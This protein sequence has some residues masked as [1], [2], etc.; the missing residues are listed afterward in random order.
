MEKK[1]LFRIV[2]II[3]LLIVKSPIVK[4]QNIYYYNSDGTINYYEKNNNVY[5]FVIHDFQRNDS[6]LQAIKN[7]TLNYCKNSWI[8]NSYIIHFSLRE[9]DNISTIKSFFNGVR[10][11][12]SNILYE[13]NESPCW[14]YNKLFVKVKEN[15]S[16]ATLLQENHIPVYNYHQ[17]GYDENT[18]VVD[19]NT[20]IDSSIICSNILFETGSVIF[21]QPDMWAVFKTA[22]VLQ[23]FQWNTDNQGQYNNTFYDIDINAPEAWNLSSGSGIKVAVID[24]GIDLNHP[25]LSSNL[26]QGVNVTDD[27]V[28]C[29][30]LGACKGNDAHG[31]ACA[32]IIA[33]ED[34]NFGVKGIAYNAE[35]IPI[36]LSYKIYDS[37]M[38]VWV[39][40]SPRIWVANAIHKAWSVYGADV[41]SC[42]WENSHQDIITNEIRGAINF[43]RNGNGCVV[44]F[45]AGNRNYPQTSFYGT[46]DTLL[47]VGA[48]SPCGERKS[49]NSCD[50]ENLGSDYGTYLDIVAPGV[51][52]PTTDIHG[53]SG[54]NPDRMLHIEN[55]GNMLFQDCDSN[56]YTLMFSGTSAAAPHVAAVAALVLSINPSLT[57]LEVKEII[58]KSAQ[59]IR[60]DLYSYDPDPV[61][62]NGSW[63][64][65][66][67][68][69]LV[70]AYAAV[71]AAGG[72]DLYT[73]DNDYDNLS[74][75]NTGLLSNIFYSPDI[76]VRKYRDTVTRS[77]SITIE[78]TNYVFVRVHNN[79][80]V[81]SLAHNDSVKIYAKAN[82]ST[83]LGVW[84]NSWIPLGAAEIPEIPAGRDTI[85][86]VK[87]EFPHIGSAVDFAI[88]SRIES[89]A[90]PL[91]FS[92]TNN[93]D[94]NVRKNN[95]IS[96][97]NVKVIDHYVADNREANFTIS[98]ISN[99]ANGWE[100]IR[101]RF[102]NQSQDSTILDFADITLELSDDLM[103]Y[104]QDYMD[105]DGV[106]HIKDNEYLVTER[107]VTLP[108]IPNSTGEY[109]VT[110]KYNFLTNKVTMRDFFNT[111]VLQYKNDIDEQDV[112]IGGFT[113]QVEKPKRTVAN[114]FH[115]NAGNDTA[116]LLNTTA[117]LHATQINED[118]TYRWY[119]KQRNF[120]YEGLNYSIIPSQTSE[121]ILEVTAESDGYRD[122]DTVKVNVLPGCI[123]SITPNP[124]S[125]NWI[126][127]SYEYASTVTSAQLLIYNTGTTT[128]VGSYDL[129]NL[130]NVS[131]LD[132]EV[133]NYP[134]GS[135]TVVLVCDNAVCHSKVLIRQ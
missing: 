16:I 48:I 86:C 30:S 65:E 99:N 135:Y 14:T 58:E 54:Y 94:T 122:L 23:H 62:P 68:Y 31:T 107:S 106:K 56:N 96:A 7:N 29:G 67:G 3:V 75:P 121:Y 133:T 35:L 50:G 110:I 73:R 91:A 134:T 52:I 109:S 47:C 22:N 5:V 45:A 64:N 38:L 51:L 118:A 66:M 53:V 55:G 123:R 84:N 103:Y 108:H 113:I 33:A 127:V 104:W 129:S 85:V 25:D 83:N 42:S 15:V 13:E 82:V 4:S 40:Y 59:K 10:Y 46:I 120:K 69:G 26:L 11:S 79:G 112:L 101:I 132:V 128:L 78:G 44:V 49:P 37:T 9:T 32:G 6:L 111:Y 17:F 115:A 80:P 100:D 20:K 27:T 105:I 102:G 71:R 21:A 28:I 125:G 95:N 98:K 114:R 97:I 119:D 124:V 43:G 1:F 72:Y 60:T 18:F 63:N 24:D 92:E 81:S 117:T 88:Y 93:A 61:H 70:D 87:V 41:L 34:N 19:L 39:N 116:V 77:Q 130:G 89:I 126:T 90:D 131:S 36:K 12:Y 76:W 2:F 57:A 8:F 74:E